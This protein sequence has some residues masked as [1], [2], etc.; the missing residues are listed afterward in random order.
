MMSANLRELLT[1]AIDGELSPAERKT[2]QKLLHESEAARKL[3]AQLKTDAARIKK[4]PRVAAPADLADN[5]LN[6]IRDRAM[7]P[8]PLP[9][10]RRVGRKFN[11]SAM[12]IW[13]NLVTA[14][15][16]LLVISMG[17]YL[18]FSA[19][20]D[21]FASQNNGYAAKDLGKPNTDVNGV[22]K[23]QADQPK[24]SAP[25]TR[26]APETIVEK[27]RDRPETGP[28]PRLVPNNSHTAP[29]IDPLPEIEPFDVN[30]I[31]ISQL[32]ALS[33]LST[34]EPA[35]TKLAR[36]MKKDELIRLDLFCQTTPKA[37][38]AVVNALKSRGITAITDSF[39]NDRIKRKAPTEVMIFTEALTPDEVAQLLSV[40]GAEDAKSGAG[41]FSTLVAAP[42][43]PSDLERLGKALGIPNVLPKPVGKVGGVDIRKPLPQGTADHVA[44]TLSK[45]GTTG[46]PPKPEKVAVVVAFS[47]MNGNPAASK[48]IKQF[49]D[50]RGERSAAAKPLMLVLRTN[51]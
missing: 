15:S 8:T 35:R 42:F 6:A 26:P 4:L 16:V 40:L 12:P 21:Y 22:A 18:Y 1:A 19:S 41:E 37:L 28:S 23:P 11:W 44:A 20:H 48:E 38:E 43:L 2:A 13:M 10:S 5:V 33:E 14:A 25:E 30:K 7:T 47:P 9:P 39:V 36:E 50:R 3:F 32:F 51:K 29:V 24:D 45:M 17:S 34:D 31:R 27:P 49:L 46:T